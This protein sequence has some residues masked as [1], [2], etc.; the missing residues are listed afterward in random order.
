MSIRIMAD[1]WDH[2][3]SD[4]GRLL[5]LLAL[6]D[7]ANDRG[8][9]WPKTKKLAKRARLSERQVRRVL[10]ELVE[11]G[12]IEMPPG[13]R[14]ENSPFRIGQNVR[15]TPT[16]AGADTDDHPD[17]T[18]TTAPYVEPSVEPPKEP[19]VE[20]Q[21]QEVWATYLQAT[22]KKPKLDD[23]RRKHIANALKI[24]GLE[25]CKLA[26]VGLTRSPHHRGENDTGTTYLDI[27]YALKGIK[28][29]SDEERIEKMAALA[30]QL[31]P[32]ASV[33][34]VEQVRIERRLEA[35]RANRSS[36]GFFEPGRAAQA[37]KDLEGWGFTLVELDKA[38]WV[39]LT[40]TGD[41]EKPS[42]PTGGADA[43]EAA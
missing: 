5:V 3:P 36:G 18:P 20:N 16:T 30:A 12:E 26:V 7:F 22:G 21:I 1:V 23:K 28:D 40:T 27:R 14:T 4:G 38:P 15:R 2:S 42:E 43:R 25:K 17:R 10:K 32:A 33:A 9:C 11:D 39:R 34:G 29:E 41:A 35:V 13:H 8:I 31:G 6:A 24:A 19:S 37:R